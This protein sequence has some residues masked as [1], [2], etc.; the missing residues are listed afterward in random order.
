M[1]EEVDVAVEQRRRFV[2]GLV[3]HLRSILDR[4]GSAEARVSALNG[5]KERVDEPWHSRDE[6]LCTNLTS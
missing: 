1:C 3:Q 5:D 4:T 6:D 2:E